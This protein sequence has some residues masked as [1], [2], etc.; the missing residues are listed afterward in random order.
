MRAE[1]RREILAVP[2]GLLWQICLFL[3]P[4]QL[5]IRAW[6][7]M[8]VTGLLFAIGLGGLYFIWLRHELREE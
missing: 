7:A 6:T 1:H 4:M 3:L 2:F 8:A 5:I